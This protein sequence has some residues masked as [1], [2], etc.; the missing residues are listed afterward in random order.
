MSKSN[1]EG[2]IEIEGKLYLASGSLPNPVTAAL[3]AVHVELQNQ[4]AA[5]WMKDPHQSNR[6]KKKI[7]AVDTRLDRADY[8]VH[9]LHCQGITSDRYDLG[10]MANPD[11]SGQKPRGLITLREIDSA[12]LLE[13]RPWLAREVASIQAGV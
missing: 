9:A 13:S 11:M 8:R 2:L 5:R 1:Y 6:P 3:A 4:L 12:A 10:N 7:L